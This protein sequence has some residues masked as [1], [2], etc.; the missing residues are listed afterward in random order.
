MVRDNNSHR[1]VSTVPRANYALFHKSNL[2]LAVVEAKDNGQSVGAGMQQVLN[3]AEFWMCLSCPAAT[4]TTCHHGTRR[5]AARASTQ[6]AEQ[7]VELI[8]S[9]GGRPQY[10]AAVQT[11]QRGLYA[12]AQSNPA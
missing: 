4:A 12:H 7:P 11:L 1:D 8:K 5:S 9:L 10:L 6:C 2:P 3:N